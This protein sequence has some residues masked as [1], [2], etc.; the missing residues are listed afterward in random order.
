MYSPNNDDRALYHFLQ[1]SRSA[2]ARKLLLKTVWSR[3]CQFEANGTPSWEKAREQ[4]LKGGARMFL[5]LEQRRETPLPPYLLLLGYFYREKGQPVPKSLP[6]ALAYRYCARDVLLQAIQPPPSP[7]VFE[8]LLASYQPPLRTAFN[9]QYT[10]A[11]LDFEDIFNDALVAF[12]QR[13][14]S[15]EREHTAQ[16]YTIFRMIFFNKAADAYRAHNRSKPPPEIPPEEGNKTDGYSDIV[17]EK[18]L[19]N[20]RFG[21]DDEADILRKAMGRLDEKCQKIIRLRYFRG[22]RLREVAE[23]IGCSTDS[24]GTRVKR[25][26][27]K[28]RDLFI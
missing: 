3:L 26:L 2:Q 13:P 7:G 17:I 18:H 15:P 4:L 9:K 11:G 27:T 24:M 21:T 25:C 23:V 20:E 8:A 19:L 10:S 12:L 22:L 14:P 16:L 28:L 6:P 5:D 1:Q